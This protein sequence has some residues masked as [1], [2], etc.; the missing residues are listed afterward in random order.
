[1]LEIISGI[2]L[3]I[4]GFLLTDPVGSY[5]PSGVAMTG[6]ALAVLAFGTFVSFVLR[7]RPRDEREEIHRGFAGR[8]GFLAGAGILMLGIVLQSLA[9]TLDPWLVYALIAM[10]VG[11]IVALLWSGYKK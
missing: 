10:V 9:H 6:L 4:F 3:V 8:V 11:K 2:L 1:M 5:M 7:E